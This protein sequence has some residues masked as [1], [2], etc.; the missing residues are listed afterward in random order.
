[1]IGSLRKNLV[2]LA[3]GAAVF[4][5]PVASASANFFEAEEYFAPVGVGVKATSN[6]NGFAI[7]GAVTVCKKGTFESTKAYIEK[8]E[9][10]EVKPTYSECFTE[11]K[12]A[13][14]TTVNTKEC[15]YA[16]KAA[17]AKTTGGTVSIKKCPSTNP[18]VVEVKG[19]E[20]CTIEVSETNNANLGQVEYINEN[21]ARYGLKASPFA[22]VKVLADVKGITYSIKGCPEGVK[23][24]TTGEYR[25]GKVEEVG[26]VVKNV[27]ITANPAKAEAVGTEFNKLKKVGIRVN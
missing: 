1:M 17:P 15:E 8:T 26:G 21:E 4:G 20:N 22:F 5:V 10:I 12:N 27:T 9:T 23:A 13:N 24:G 25:E 19:V 7:A 3:V 18:I 2:A 6:F 11:I 16:F 14:A